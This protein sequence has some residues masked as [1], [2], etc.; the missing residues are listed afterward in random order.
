MNNN[1]SSDLEESSDESSSSE[2]N[3]YSFD[4]EGE[5]LERKVVFGSVKSLA[6]EEKHY[7]I[8]DSKYT[9]NTI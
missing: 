3:F 7:H 2:E 5:S 8:F 4:S 1:L 9:A 6:H